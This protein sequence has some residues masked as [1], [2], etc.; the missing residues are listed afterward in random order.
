MGF[1][2]QTLP[3]GRENTLLVSRLDGPSTEIVKRMIDD[4]LATEKTGLAGTA[5]FDARW[6]KPSGEKAKNLQGYRL[7]DHFIHLAAERV[8]SSG[9]LPRSQSTT[10]PASFNPANARMRPFMSAGIVCANTSM[11]L[12][13]SRVRWATTS[14]ATNAKP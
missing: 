7:Y 8:A 5:Y 6:A 12:P 13:G 9:R 2:G 4:S 14:P 1:R 3:L 10:S 11:P